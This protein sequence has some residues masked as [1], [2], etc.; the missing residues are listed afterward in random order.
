MG[1]A[2][3][4]KENRQQLYKQTT[5]RTL[6][7][8]GRTKAGRRLR[9]FFAL[10]AVL[11]TGVTTTCVQ[12]LEL[13][14]FDVDMGTGSFGGDDSD[15][16]QDSGAVEDTDSGNY[17]DNG[18]SAENAW[19]TEE[20]ITAENSTQNEWEDAFSAGQYESEDSNG[21]Y[22]NDTIEENQAVDEQTENAGTVEGVGAEPE[23][24]ENQSSEEEILEESFL[25]P[26]VQPTA[27]AVPT[28]T[29]TPLPTRK[30]SA[31]PQPTQNILIV[32]EKEEEL[33]DEECRQEM[34]LLYCK[35]E[36]QNAS[37]VKIHP[38]PQLAAAVLSVRVNGKE[39]DWHTVGGNIFLNMN[40]EQE[41]AEIETAVMCSREL[42]WTEA[43]K[44]AIL[45]YTIF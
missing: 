17:S 20:N 21:S 42:S 45:T 38:N 35:K 43:K 4:G 7:G 9:T 3:G 23:I 33:P 27:T 40:E 14:G 26:S 29:Q 41:H 18:N 22:A 37:R 13:G 44:N 39:A 12:A 11:L 19:S 15:W 30:V 8:T 24:S 5:D 2:D 28:V 10:L 34:Q 31:T 25:T 16:D 1:K 32:P 6:E 36:I